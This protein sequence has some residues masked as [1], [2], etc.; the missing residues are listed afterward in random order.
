ML[1]F[2]KLPL[3]PPVLKSNGNIY[4]P[5]VPEFIFTPAEMGF[6]FIFWD[7]STYLGPKKVLG[8]KTQQFKLEPNPSQAVSLGDVSYLR[9]SLCISYGTIIRVEYF[10]RRNV[11]LK[12]WTC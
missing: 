3:G 7:K 1:R 9:V 8:L 10:N 2:R 6:S 11:F 5:I 4:K 12:K